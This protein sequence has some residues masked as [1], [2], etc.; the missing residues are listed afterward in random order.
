[1]PSWA[2]TGPGTSFGV[3]VT[4]NTPTPFERIRRTVCST[5]SRNAFD[6]QRDLD[7]G[8]RRDRAVV[9]AA[10]EVDRRTLDLVRGL[11]RRSEICHRGS[12][13]ILTR[14]VGS[15]QPGAVLARRRDAAMIRG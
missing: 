15:T 4:K 5:E 6:A 11:D 7:D 13:A 2:S 3:C 12:R 8:F 14:C 10:A 1:L 9:H